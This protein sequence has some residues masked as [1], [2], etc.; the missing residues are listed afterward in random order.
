MALSR[1]ESDSLIRAMKYV[2]SRQAELG[3]AIND[4]KQRENGGERTTNISLSY[5]RG[6]RIID[7]YGRKE[8]LRIYIRNNTTCPEY[9]AVKLLIQEL[10]W[11]ESFPT[12]G[13]LKYSITIPVAYCE[14]VLGAMLD[15]RAAYGLEDL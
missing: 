6:K 8:R 10:C 4:S 7:I 14:K 11:Q 3:Y 9:L 15:A 13:N 1:S 5:G 2:K 12:Q